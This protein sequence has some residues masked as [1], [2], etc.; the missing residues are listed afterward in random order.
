MSLNSSTP[1]LVG[2]AVVIVLPGCER[3]TPVNEPGALPRG[4]ALDR[5]PQINATTFFAHGHLRERAGNFQ[6]AEVNY[7][8]AVELNPEFVSARNR[9]GITLN[10]LGRHAEATQQF[11]KAIAV[12]PGKAYLYNNLG[13][14]LY[15]EQR[16]NQAE[17]ALVTAV[18]IKP[19]FGRARMNLGLVYAKQGRLNEAYDELRKATDEADA[20]FNM[21]MLL[22]EAGKYA[23][24]AKYLETAISLKPKFEAAQLQLGEVARLA[25]EAEALAA[26]Q[27]AK[28]AAETTAELT[29]ASKDVAVKPNQDDG[30]E[31]ESTVAETS[32]VLAANGDDT[33]ADVATTEEFGTE[34]IVSIESS[35]VGLDVDA[36]D[37]E[38][39]DRREGPGRDGTDNVAERG[40]VD[41]DTD[42]KSNSIATNN[43]TTDATGG[44][45]GGFDG[46]R[47]EA[48]GDFLTE[49]DAAD[50]T[51]PIRSLDVPADAGLDGAPVGRSEA[52]EPMTAPEVNSQVAD[53]ASDAFDWG[54]AHGWANDPTT[55]GMVEL[56]PS[57]VS[58]AARHTAPVGDAGSDPFAPTDST[59]VFGVPGMLHWNTPVSPD[60][61]MFVPTRPDNVID[62]KRQVTPLDAMTPHDARALWDLFPNWMQAVKQRARTGRDVNGMIDPPYLKWVLDQIEYSLAHPDCDPTPFVEDLKVLVGTETPTAE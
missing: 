41:D 43:S 35:T 34:S 11:R 46:D 58:L 5:E 8:K 29:T 2:L 14:S 20:C 59:D 22:T 3:T 48:D 57:E 60:E 39:G 15:L 10:K 36:S 45:G 16:L 12:D 51:H 26:A 33:N 32:E 27:A 61:G 25:A 40:N 9:L 49:P 18:R 21:G 56:V 55:S 7:R 53:P 17:D 6:A 31:V 38:F 50:L 62:G 4:T 23:A 30:G 44:N 42:A 1:W 37:Y 24:A 13:F 28:G 19:E 52:V 54:A 47:N